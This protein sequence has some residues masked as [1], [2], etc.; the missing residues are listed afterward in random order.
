MLVVRNLAPGKYDL[1]VDGRAVGAWTHEQLARGVNIS[2]ATPDGWVPGGPW[3]AQA[4]LLKMITQSRNELAQMQKTAVHYFGSESATQPAG[5]H[6][7]DINAELETLQRETA[8]P[9][10]YRF[11]ISAA[12]RE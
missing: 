6:A 11:V 10:P 4:A 1:K 7:S 2:S 8:R 5:V 12:A 9:R 3:D